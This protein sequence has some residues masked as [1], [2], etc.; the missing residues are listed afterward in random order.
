MLTIVSIRLD[1][2]FL[3]ENSKEEI[4]GM[5]IEKALRIFIL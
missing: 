3:L 1:N 5:T 4:L 2:L